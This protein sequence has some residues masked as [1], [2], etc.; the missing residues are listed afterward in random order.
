[1]SAINTAVIEIVEAVLTSKGQFEDNEAFSRLMNDLM[2]RT[3]QFWHA[4]KDA[5]PPQFHG[6]FR[7][8]A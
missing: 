2:E 1:M 8:Y 4:H 6:Y 5:I 3:E 7:K